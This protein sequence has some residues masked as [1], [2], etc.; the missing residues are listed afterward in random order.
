[1]LLAQQ[2]QQRRA[3]QR[4]TN[5]T[6]TTTTTHTSSSSGRASNIWWCCTVL[7]ALKW[8]EVLF[9]IV[10][11]A[12]LAPIVCMSP[13]QYDYVMG[14]AAFC[15]CVTALTLII[16]FLRLHTGTLAALPWRIMEIAFNV[17]AVLLYLAATGIGIYHC[18]KLFQNAH[19]EMF[20]DNQCS[21]HLLDSAITE[22][23]RGRMAAITAFCAINA[24]LHVLSA[25]YA[26]GIFL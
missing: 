13:G 4:A 6:T 5:T 7:A 18:I 17:L 1:M 20:V 26:R 8:L 3:Q 10:V 24:I 9:A 2:Q 15:L 23:W 11:V 12:V 16:Y 14:A 22:E 19:K 21:F 25:V